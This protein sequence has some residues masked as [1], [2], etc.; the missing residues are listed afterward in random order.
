MNKFKKFSEIKEKELNEYYKETR[1]GRKI[2]KK[3]AISAAENTIK[4]FLIKEEQQ[5]LEA[6]AFGRSFSEEFSKERVVYLEISEKLRE[7]FLNKLINLLVDLNPAT[8]YKDNFKTNLGIFEARVFIDHKKHPFV[9]LKVT[10]Y[11]PIDEDLVTVNLDMNWYRDV[12]ASIC[13][14]KEENLKVSFNQKVYTL[15]SDSL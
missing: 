5:L 4:D 2:V 6:D 7:E 10:F 12:R 3:E 15:Y 14:G 8:K 9:T 1:K 13:Y 11:S